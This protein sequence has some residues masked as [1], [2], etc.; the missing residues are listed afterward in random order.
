MSDVDDLMLEFEDK[1]E[2]RYAA[3]E[4][5]TVKTL[6][7]Q[8]AKI[9]DFDR[10]LKCVEQT[11]S[12]SNL[13]ELDDSLSSLREEFDQLKHNSV[14]FTPEV[15]IERFTS[16]N[17]PGRSAEEAPL[18]GSRENAPMAS[19]TPSLSPQKK[20]TKYGRLFVQSRSPSAW[21]PPNLLEDVNDRKLREDLEKF[22]DSKVSYAEK[23]SPV[24]LAFVS[25]YFNVIRR[26][27]YSGKHFIS[28]LP[29]SA[30]VAVQY[31]FESLL[32][33]NNL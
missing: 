28:S 15:Q 32:I 5:V 1:F 7:E 17:R 29:V 6:K 33:P 18:A 11:I 20:K 30:D 4:T 21:V 9:E 8:S 2:A 27:E 12:N 14:R 22:Y 13:S 26:G 19:S 10:R 3:L 24:Q 31:G 16:L 23:L 25:Y